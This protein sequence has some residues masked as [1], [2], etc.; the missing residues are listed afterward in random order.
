MF[1]YIISD[2]TTLDSSRS[3]RGDDVIINLNLNPNLS[4][5]YYKTQM[6]N[7]SGLSNLPPFDEVKLTY[8][9]DKD[10]NLK[11]LSVDETYTAT[12]EG[13]PVPAET[14]NKIEYYYYPSVQKNI[15]S[16][17]EQ[18]NYTIQED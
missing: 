13:V 14:Q 10:L 4:T 5:F 3:I 18:I 7:I 8:T 11:H 1:I 15:P 16:S 17:S 6:Q 9:L 12:K 2:K